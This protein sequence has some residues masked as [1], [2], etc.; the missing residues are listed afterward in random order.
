MRRAPVGRRDGTVRHVR[1]VRTLQTIQGVSTVTQ[2]ATGI[3]ASQRLT[4][5]ADSDV[6]S[7]VAKAVIDSGVGLLGLT[8]EGGLEGLFMKL[9]K[10]K[11][12]RDV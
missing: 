3:G 5:T 2:A 12:S 7:K 1:M 11:E 4:L 8:A 10:P 9:T 6:R